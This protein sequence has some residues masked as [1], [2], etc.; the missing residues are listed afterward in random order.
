MKI[1]ELLRDSLYKVRKTRDPKMVGFVSLVVSECEYVGKKDNRE[2]TNDECLKVLK[3][4]KAG[5]DEC[6]KVEKDQ[7]K[8][9]GYVKE[10]SWV[11]DIIEQ[12]TPEQLTQNDIETVIKVFLGNNK[13]GSIGDLMKHFSSKFEKGTYEPRLV[14]ETFKR[15]TLV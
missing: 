1:I 11:S 7:G 10:S 9:I 5:I 14:S 8:I 2:P 6:I 3:K 12:F 4:I 13:E 15:L